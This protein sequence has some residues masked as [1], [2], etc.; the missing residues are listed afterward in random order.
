MS[1]MEDNKLF[2][3]REYHDLSQRRVGEIIGVRQQ[4]YAEWEKGK[5]IIP[6]KHLVTL[7]KYYHVSLDY[8]TGLSP[9]KDIVYY[10]TSLD[11]KLIGKKLIYLRKSKRLKQK[12]MAKSLNTPASTLCSYEKG[13]NLILTAFLYQICKEYNVSMDWVIGARKKSQSS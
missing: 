13:H 1:S 2:I 3:L 8:L 10:Y 5:K 9:N 7:A 12:D 4:T 11:K 6:L